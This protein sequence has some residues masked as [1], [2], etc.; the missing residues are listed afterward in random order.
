MGKV[1][2][3]IKAMKDGT[4]IWKLPQYINVTYR[5]LFYIKNK[6]VKSDALRDNAY[7]RLKREFAN[8]IEKANYDGLPQTHSNKVWICWLQGYEQAPVLVKACI[9]SAKKNMP[10]HEVIILT[11]E[12][13]GDYIELPEHICKKYQQGKI[14]RTHY[15]DIVRIALLC[16]WGG[17]WI[18]STVLCTE[19]EFPEYITALPLF[20]YKKLDLSRRDDDNMVASSWLIASTTNQPILLLTRDL[21]YA[22]WE[23]YNYL[24]DYFLFHLFFAMATRKF[25]EDWDRIP[26]YNNHSPHILQF[27]LENTYDEQRWDQIMKMSAFHKLNWHNDYSKFPNSN[28]AHIIEST[29]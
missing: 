1:K 26:V 28:Y 3:A 10:N 18:D 29:P 23:K 16:R 8:Q 17:L 5:R 6:N 2:S 4:L 22:Y 7:R 15:S 12:N 14:S 20:V 19:K 13:I 21:L 11:D 9:D 27:E 24:V 25:K